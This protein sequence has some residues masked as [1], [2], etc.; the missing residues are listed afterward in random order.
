[1]LLI[2]TKRI[3]VQVFLNNFLFD[4]VYRTLTS[5]CT[6][7]SMLGRPETQKHYDTTEEVNDTY[8][9]NNQ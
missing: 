7:Q 6:C 4:F 1:M 9:I 5:P 2:F 8:Q 3:F